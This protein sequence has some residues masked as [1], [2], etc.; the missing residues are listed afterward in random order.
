MSQIV[1]SLSSDNKAIDEYT[2]P[3]SFS[4][5]SGS[6]SEG[7]TTDKYE[8]GVPGLPLEVVQEGLQTRFESGAQAGSRVK[9]R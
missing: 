6:S 1:L 4:G 9:N 7:N 2:N 8:F 5:S 3:S